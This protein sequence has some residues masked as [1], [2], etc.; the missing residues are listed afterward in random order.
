MDKNVGGTDKVIRIVVG[1]AVLSLL[2]LLKHPDRWLGLIGLIPI[3]TATVGW[4]PAYSIFGI[5]TCK[6]KTGS[7]N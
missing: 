6:T 1:L 5:N 7:P 4:C 2:F 3:L